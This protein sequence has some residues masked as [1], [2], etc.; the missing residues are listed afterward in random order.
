MEEK[1]KS[2]MNN[3]SDVVQLVRQFLRI[4]TSNPPG[5]EEKAVLFLIDPDHFFLR[6]PHLLCH[7]F[8]WIGDVAPKC[9]NHAGPGTCFKEACICYR[10][11]RLRCEQSPRALFPCGPKRGEPCHCVYGHTP[12][13]S[14]TGRSRVK[15]S[16]AGRPECH[17]LG[18][19]DPLGPAEFRQRMVDLILPRIDAPGDG[20][21]GQFLRRRFK[22]CLE[23]END[24]AVRVE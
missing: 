10:R 13:T 2:V 17:Q 3:S 1:I 21:G 14:R 6:K 22:C 18:T 4:D 19:I 11:D 15:F 9:S 24:E 12:R 5:N 16:G 20:L 23:P 7:P 8:D